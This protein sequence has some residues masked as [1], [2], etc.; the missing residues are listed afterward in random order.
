M[1]YAPVMA[2]TVI[3]A[4]VDR[5]ARLVR[6]DTQLLGLQARAGGQSDGPLVIPQLA[7]LAKLAMRMET[8]IS[9]PVLAGDD[10][11]DI[12]MW[13]RVVPHPEG[14]TI[15][16]VD[17]EETERAARMAQA[18]EVTA[19][20]PLTVDAIIAAEPRWEWS[21]DAQLRL[22]ALVRTDEPAALDNWIGRSVSEFF[23]LSPDAQG[24]FPLFQAL[25]R[26][27]GFE[28]QAAHI[29]GVAESVD[30][31][32]T[33]VTDVAG[34]FSGYQGV[35]GNSS[36]AAP[37]EADGELVLT[38]MIDEGPSGDPVEPPQTAIDH[39]HSDLMGFGPQV[40]DF[41]RRIDGALRRPLGRIIANA[42]TISG[43]LEGPIR[44]D[45]ANYAKDIA[46]A[47]RHLMGLIDDLADLQAIERPDFQPAKE[48]VD[49]ADIG[50]RT[51]GLLA[52]K[53]RDRSIRI[54]APD[55]DES[56]MAVGEFRRIL[57]ILINLVGNAIR[58]SPEGSMIWIRAESENGHA[59]VTVADQ[60]KGLSIE[61]QGKIFEKFERLGRD[62]SGGSG[63]GLYIAR[64]LARAMHGD[65]VID[66]APGQGA[67]FSLILPS[68]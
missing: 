13:V 44:Q 34:R 39:D 3:R 18:T 52:M 57:Q 42:E 7:R 2:Q 35:A 1:E 28:G 12:S 40:G 20:Q 64:R 46:E 15:E 9:R 33:A 23:R 36:A 62:D 4:E 14:A 48:D 54:D 56:V 32:A 25:A 55:L 53:A 29:E 61:D 26:Q 65:I 49:L 43:K 68:K 30:I 8:P 11:C 47:G 10:D 21:C 17:W 50:R 59:M 45:Y 5:N 22:T 60:G 37:D 16:M 38:E 67:R 41:S 24:F 19:R 51:G 66:S 6:S 31:W 27:E 58:Y 63:L